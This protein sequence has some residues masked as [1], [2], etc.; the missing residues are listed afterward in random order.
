MAVRLQLPTGETLESLPLLDGVPDWN[1]AATLAAQ[2]IP[3]SIL[4]W[5]MT[6]LAAA[7]QQQN[8]VAIAPLLN[9][10]AGHPGVTRYVGDV[11]MLAIRLT[12][13][14]S[15]H[16]TEI[17]GAKRATRK[18]VA[19]F[20]TSARAFALVANVIAATAPFMDIL[21]VRLSSPPVLS[22]V[23]GR[24]EMQAEIEKL[25]AF[26]SALQDIADVLP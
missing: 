9:A 12:Q 20:D 25:N 5:W 10:G 7:A 24:S 14:L 2:L 26:S 21:N 15:A 8:T 22:P 3:A 13:A 16:L 4:I 19:T 6:R 18:T 17:Q 11:I 23:T 1:E